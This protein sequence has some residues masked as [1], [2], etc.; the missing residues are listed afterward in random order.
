MN[1]LEVARTLERFV[2]GRGGAWEWDDFLATAFP[3][4]SYL[5]EIQARMSVLNIEFPPDQMGHYC[6]AQGI[7]V[8]V[9]CVKELRSGNA[10]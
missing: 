10:A 9:E 6:S 3:N 4:D 1:R 8:I 2:E 7:Q 5:S